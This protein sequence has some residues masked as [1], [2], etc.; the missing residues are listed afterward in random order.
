M[1]RS[2]SKPPLA[3]GAERLMLR[4]IKMTTVNGATNE[5]LALKLLQ[6]MSAHTFGP[7]RSSAQALDPY[8]CRASRPC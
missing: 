1:L 8:F 2:R 5:Q 4:R 3:G 6:P 7:E